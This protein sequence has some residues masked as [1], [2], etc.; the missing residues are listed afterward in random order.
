MPAVAL[1]E[2]VGDFNISMDPWEQT[3]AAPQGWAAH[4]RQTVIPVQGYIQ[5]RPQDT[6]L[7]SFGSGPPA[8]AATA[9]TNLS[10]EVA[11]RDGGGKAS[12]SVSILFRSPLCSHTCRHC[13][14]KPCDVATEHDDHICF[15][16]EQRILFP[17]RIPKWEMQKLPICDLWCHECATQRCCTRGLDAN[18]VFV[19]VEPPQGL[20]DVN[21][22]PFRK[23]CDRLKSFYRPTLS[24]TARCTGFNTFI[25]SVMPYTIS[26]FGLTTADLNRLRQASARFI[27][28]RHWLEAEILPHVL[29]YF[30]IATLL[31]PATGLYLREGNP[32]EDLGHQNG[33]EEC[34]NPRQ[35]S[36][37]LALMDLWSP[38]VGLEELV[39]AVAAT[40]GPIP[41]KLSALK[42]VILNR[43]E[44]EAKS[45]IIKKIHKEGWSGGIS[46]EWVVLLAGAPKKLCNGTGRYTLLRWAVNQD[47]D[48]WLS[49]RGTRHQQKCG[50]CGL[51]GESFPHGYYQPPLCESCIRAVK[52]NA[53]ALAPWSQS[54]CDAY[55]AEDCQNQ[56]A[57]WTQEWNVQPAHVVVCRACGCGDN[58]IGHWTRW[59]VVPLIVAIAILQPNEKETTL[60]QLAGVGSR[61]A[62][63]CTLVL[64]IFFFFLVSRTHTK[65]L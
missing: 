41:K 55:T 38:Y 29:R 24:I 39:G 2:R 1:A 52:L 49:M 11:V 26:Y 50:T 47:D 61:E 44:L 18:G 8:T 40:H 6:T 5:L 43:M 17:E 7:P 63:V 10:T 45:R 19:P 3:G 57:N 42:K 30:G 48:V 4:A 62:I 22:G 32:V 46:P 25:L 20:N 35:K 33:R 23:L 27:L 59:C 14:C 13:R 56:L 34:G 60:D 9:D 15:N 51:P 58:T 65:P 54:L 37:V 31:D 16:C 21:T 28:K 53:W 64:A 36:V 12:P